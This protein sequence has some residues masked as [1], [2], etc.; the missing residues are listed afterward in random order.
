MQGKTW[1]RA[2][3]PAFA[4]RS[5]RPGAVCSQWRTPA[6]RGASSRRPA[7]VLVAWFLEEESSACVKATSA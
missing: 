4:E 3:A 7:L 5:G 2:P 1:P 6:G